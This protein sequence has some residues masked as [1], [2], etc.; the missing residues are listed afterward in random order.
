MR[1]ILYPPTTPWAWMRQRPHHLLARAARSGYRVVWVDEHPVPNAPGVAEV[2]PN[3]LVVND[4]AVLPRL[5]DG[6]AATYISSP[7][8]LAQLP[9]LGRF[10][11]RLVFDYIDRFAAWEPHV[12]HALATADVVLASS[13]DLWERA[14]AVRND[15]LL[16][17]NGV[18]YER[19][20]GE[21]PEPFDLALI[22]NPIAL[23]MGAIADWID[24]GLLLEL[25]QA[26]PEV[27]VVTVGPHLGAGLIRHFPWPSNF[28]CLGHRPYQEVAGYLQAASVLL[29][30]FG[31]NEVSRATNP[32][33]MWEY[34]AT[35]K[36][37]V[38]T[39]MEEAL[40]H[41]EAGLLEV[42]STHA[43]FIARVQD[44]LGGAG[45]P[46]ARRAV[47]RGNDWDARWAQIQARLEEVWP[48]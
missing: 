44:A 4:A 48:A 7:V 13:R 34:M 30:P 11:K 43:E 19:F 16:V 21:E 37:I 31:S 12:D 29:L 17:P 9:G 39:P 5:L 3:L 20:A 26:L 32:C 14:A 23:Y 25:A 33:K 45:D 40:P 47:A 6:D 24:T 41:A 38:A 8:S 42:A 27:S 36:P 22:P 15:A 46:D 1:T 18:E 35:G 10:S 28:Y 2:E